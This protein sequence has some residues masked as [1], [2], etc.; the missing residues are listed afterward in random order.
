M[1]CVYKEINM[2][3]QVV[4]ENAFLMHYENVPAFKAMVNRSGIAPHFIL[5]SISQAQGEPINTQ[6]IL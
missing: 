5:W 3:H 2:N 1:H 4:L 6:N